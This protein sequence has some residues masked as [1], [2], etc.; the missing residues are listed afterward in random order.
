MG[1]PA[2]GVCSWSINRSR[3]I[4]SIRVAA[5]RFGVRVVH[6]GFFDEQTLAGTSAQAVRK[7]AGDAGVEISSTFAAFPGETYKSIATVAATGG[8]L[9]DEHF[10][11]RL[12]MTRRVADLAAEL[13]VASVAIHAGTVPDDRACDAHKIL[14]DRTGQAADLLMDRALVL[15]LET[16]RE[17]AQT[18]NGFIDAVGRENVGVNLDPGNLVLYG[19]DDPVRAVR[20]L[21][22]RIRHVHLKDAVASDQPGVTFGTEV[23]L[24]T[25]EASIARVVSK[26]RASGYDG[27][28]IV[29]RTAGRGD[30]GGLDESI[31]YLRSLLD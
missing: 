16:G 14:V 20:T 4:E 24:G 10:D 13:G 3:P 22:G 8:Y 7:A 29:E 2:V 6:L 11:A 28:L 31:E 21:R 12:D 19:A 5:D 30:P 27:P 15:L 18:L 9:P 17:S 23:T 1:P 25:G 26:L